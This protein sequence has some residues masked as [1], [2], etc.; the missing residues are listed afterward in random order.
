M[1][2]LTN[3]NFTTTPST[4]KG[5]CTRCLQSFIRFVDSGILEKEIDGALGLAGEMPNGEIV[6]T[7]RIKRIE[8]KR[9]FR[10]PINGLMVMAWELKRVSETYRVITDDDREYY[11]RLCEANEEMISILNQVF[12]MADKDYKKNFDDDVIEGLRIISINGFVSQL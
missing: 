6:K 9:I 11:I 3:W 4:S 7:R 2:R 1:E 12:E 8:K 5:E 10:S